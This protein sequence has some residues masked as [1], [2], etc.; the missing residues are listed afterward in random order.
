MPDKHAVLSPSAAGAW[1]RCPGYV[2]ANRDRPDTS[3]AASIEGTR[4]H[5]L[6]EQCLRFNKHAGGFQGPH[7]DRHGEWSPDAEMVAQIDKA[8]LWLEE[9]V[10]ENPV[11][12][13][14]P[15]MKV[16]I[17]KYIGLPEGVCWGTSDLIIVSGERVIVVDLKYGR[18]PVSAKGNE[19]LILYAAGAAGFLEDDGA[20]MNAEPEVEYD[21]L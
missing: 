18:V 17:G 2:E 14:Q 20:G 9:L 19:Q 11:D 13:L 21:F 1:V 3:S 5:W 16:E 8:L 12:V 10:G 7:K 6:F 4:A 15:E